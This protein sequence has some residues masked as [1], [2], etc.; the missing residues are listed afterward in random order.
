MQTTGSNYLSHVIKKKYPKIAKYRK[1]VKKTNPNTNNL[2]LVK[3]K[4]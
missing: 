2:S 3:K 4:T 1:T